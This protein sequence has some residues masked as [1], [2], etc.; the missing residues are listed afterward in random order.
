MY[1]DNKKEGFITLH[2]S[3]LNWEWWGDMNVR[4]LFIY[5]LL[6]ANYKDTKWQ[7]IEIKRGSFVASLSSLSEGVGITQKQIRTAL[8]KLINSGELASKKTNKYRI[9]TVKNYSLYQDMG[10]QMAD[11]RQTEGSQGA[12]DKEINKKTNKPLSHTPPELEKIFVI[13]GFYIPTADLV[14]LLSS[15]HPTVDVEK[16]LKRLSLYMAAN[17]SRRKEKTDIEPYIQWW[18]ADDEDKGRNLK[19][20][21]LDKREHKSRNL[22]SN[23]NGGAYDIPDINEPG[24][25]D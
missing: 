14:E 3:I 2:R 1:E 10:N 19:E 15:E 23:E 7:G 9:I 22:Y 11:K 18:V 17:P 20:K 21:L 8:D 16:S 25:F 5:C 13:G 24:I 12:T 4:N 6:K